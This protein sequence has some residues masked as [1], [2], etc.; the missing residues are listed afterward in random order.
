MTAEN[1]VAVFNGDLRG[2]DLVGESSVEKP[3]RHLPRIGND[4]SADAAIQ[5]A[6]VVANTNHEARCTSAEFAQCVY[7]SEAETFNQ[8]C[9]EFGWLELR[10]NSGNERVPSPCAIKLFHRRFDSTSHRDP[11]DEL[12]YF[13]KWISIGGFDGAPAP[14][15]WL[16]KVREY[17]AR[18]KASRTVADASS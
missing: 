17:I 11:I 10:V 3:V 9:I 7:M 18:Q 15:E 8:F 13:L 4:V 14:A 2:T 5:V 16:S 6:C 1:M 12:S